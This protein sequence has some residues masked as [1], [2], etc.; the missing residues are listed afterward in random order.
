M[1]PNSAGFCVLTKIA[2]TGNVLPT[3][4]EED[5]SS[6]T[7]SCEDTGF[8]WFM[9]REFDKFGKDAADTAWLI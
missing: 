9:V 4:T 6:Q 8:F 7:R 2:R 1:W 3:L 5:P